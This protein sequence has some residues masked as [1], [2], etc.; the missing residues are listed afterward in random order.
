MWDGVERRRF[1]RVKYSCLVT[2]Q[3]GAPATRVVLAHTEDIGVGGVCV[4]IKRKEKVSPQIEV[5]L[6]LDLIDTMPQVA[7][8]GTISW[9]REISPSQEDQP[10]GYK[11]GIQFTSL[12]DEPRRRIQNIVEHLSERGASV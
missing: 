2:V 6:K 10:S 8:K 4:I 9:V 3:E 11:I 7:S 1:P 12:Q 5:N